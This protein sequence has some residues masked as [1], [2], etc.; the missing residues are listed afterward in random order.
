VPPRGNDCSAV[1]PKSIQAR[2]TKFLVYDVV[3][4]DTVSHLASCIAGEDV[5]DLMVA[6]VEYRF[7]QVNRLPVT[8]EW[9]SDNGSCYVAGDTRSFARDIGLE[10]RTTPLESPQSNGMAEAFVRTIKRD[11]VRV[12]PRPDSKPAHLHK[13]SQTFLD[14]MK[15]IAA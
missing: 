12:S 9:L 3:C 4:T 15:M 6:A 8:I 10:P 11:Y 14:A 7:G 13:H 1:G 2:S 5:R